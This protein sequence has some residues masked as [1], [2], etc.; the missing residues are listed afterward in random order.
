M[1]VASIKAT[2]NNK[3]YLLQPNQNISRLIN[4]YKNKDEFS[5][6]TNSNKNITD[7]DKD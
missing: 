2:N 6:S 4:D 5:S 3:N 7:I 1:P